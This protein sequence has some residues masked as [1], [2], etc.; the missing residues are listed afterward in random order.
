V[1]TSNRAEKILYCEKHSSEKIK[2]RG[3]EKKYLAEQVIEKYEDLLAEKIAMELI[4]NGY[5]KE[6]EERCDEMMYRASEIIV[7]WNEKYGIEE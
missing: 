5:E 7:L 4:N 6:I 2:K 1:K 3:K